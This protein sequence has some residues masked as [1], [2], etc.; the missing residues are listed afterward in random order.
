MERPL[1][2]TTSFAA[3]SALTLENHLTLAQLKAVSKDSTIPLTWLA[4]SDASTTVRNDFISLFNGT[5]TRE[6]RRIQTRLFG[7]SSL[8]RLL[9]PNFSI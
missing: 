1:A 7:D 4:T 8:K 3:T 5:L 2:S 6:K 9:N